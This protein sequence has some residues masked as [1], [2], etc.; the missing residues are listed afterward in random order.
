[1][2][3]FN[4]TNNT[5]CPLKSLKRLLKIGAIT[6]VMAHLIGCADD[7]QTSSPT[8][9]LTEPDHTQLL[10]NTKQAL[11]DLDL[12][13]VASLIT[14]IDV[15]RPLPDHS[16][17]LA[18]AVETQEP[19]LVNLLLNNGA[20]VNINNSNRFT[21]IIQAC[22]Y[23]NS[24]IINALL[25][26]GADVNAAITDGTNAFQLC[27]GS[28]SSID[29][30]RMINL[31]ANIS[32]Q[33]AQGQTPLMWA[34]NYGKVDNI[35]YLINQ[36]ANINHQS[37]EGYSPLFFAIKS[38]NLTAIK[39]AITNGADLTAIA[40]D[41]TTAAQ[42]ATYTANYEFLNWYADEL[43]SLVSQD[44]AEKVLTAFD[45]EGYQLL[46]AAIN[47]NQPQLVAKLIKIGASTTTVSEPSKLNWRYE[48]NFKTENYFPPQLTPLELAKKNKFTHLISM[49]SKE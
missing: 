45:R 28:A 18:W 1:M 35:N 13:L 4:L 5:S 14:K 10:L 19:K 11:L 20:T 23:G 9:I 6:L 24:H 27:A 34:A 43:H 12:S 33:N 38:H 30:A 32:A 26:K 36:G 37:N 42:L 25:D 39:T 46:H 41:S 8:V 49:L 3:Y 21:P 15:N 40:K 29:L 44:Q 7:T 47:A 31:G 16:S 2:T 48:A 22:R 17:L